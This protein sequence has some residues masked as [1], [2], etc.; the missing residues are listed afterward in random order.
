MKRLEFIS[1]NKSYGE[2]KVLNDISFSIYDREFVTI[3]G[4]NGSGKSTLLNLISDPKKLDNGK[5]EIQDR[6]SI[7]YLDQNY[8]DTIFP[9][10]SNISNLTLP[11]MIQGLSKI[12]SEKQ[13]EILIDEFNINFAKKKYPY[14]LSGGQQQQLAILRS[15]ISNPKLLLLD[16][17]FGALD[18]SIRRQISNQVLKFWNANKNTVVMVTHDI[19]EAILLSD[20]IF[21]LSNGRVN[22]NAIIYIQFQRPRS[23]NLLATKEFGNT[24]RKILEAL[25]YE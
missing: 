11:L 23:I 8:K 21:L 25:N 1:V 19:D 18:Y 6:T 10:K 22:K 9:W 5:I 15:F 12:E 3:L 4:A 13:A 16:E 17:P 7:S 2:H 14:E 20:R 24:K